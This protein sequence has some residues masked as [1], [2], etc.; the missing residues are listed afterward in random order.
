VVPKG[1]EAEKVDLDALK[2]LRKP[3]AESIFK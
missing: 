2:K 3:K 1:M